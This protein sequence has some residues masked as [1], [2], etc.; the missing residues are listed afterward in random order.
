MR[1]RVWRY[2]RFILV[3][4]IVSLPAVQAADAALRPRAPAVNSQAWIGEPSASGYDDCPDTAVLPSWHG[5]L[6]VHG[7]AVPAV[8]TRLLHESRDS[9]PIGHRKLPQ[10]SSDD[11]SSS[12]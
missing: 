12:H 6:V 4:L 11:G 9:M 8:L 10:P 7:Y 5:T 3:L 1:N 2:G